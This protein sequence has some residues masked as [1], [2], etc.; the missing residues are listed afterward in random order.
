MTLTEFSLEFDLLYNNITSNLSPGLNEYEKSVFLTKAQE[1]VVKNHFS[2][3]SNVKQEGFNNSIK[4]DTDFSTLLKTISLNN[5]IIQDPNPINTI[6]DRIKRFTFESDYLYI[7]NEICEIQKLDNNGEVIDKLTTAV[8]PLHYLEYARLVN[9]PYSE[10][11]LYT[12]WRLISDEILT[13]TTTFDL[14]IRYGWSFK[15]YIIRYV[16]KPRPIILINLNEIDSNLTINNINTA[17]ECE[18]NTILHTEILNRAVELAK[19]TF[20]GNSPDIV[21][22]NQRNE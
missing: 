14:V 22:I 18:L 20:L 2:I 8:V 1:E 3:K 19:I 11:N 5:G 12:T 17:S 10:P 9:G 13:N 7:I 6:S 15:N 21:N 16:K 4:R